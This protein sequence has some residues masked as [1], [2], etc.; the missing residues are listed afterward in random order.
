MH[1]GHRRERVEQRVARV[2]EE[3]VVAGDRARGIEAELGQE[4]GRRGREERV[5]DHRDRHRGE[6]RV[7]DEAEAAAVAEVED[8]QHQAAALEVEVRVAPAGD[9]GRPAGADRPVLDARLDQQAERA[10]GADQVA[11]VGEGE[12]HA[13]VDGAAGVA[14]GPVGGGEQEELED[15]VER[16][17]AAGGALR[18]RLA[19]TV[20][21]MR[22]IPAA[23]PAE[24]CADPY[25][26][27]GSW[28]QRGPS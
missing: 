15:E 9:L 4:A 13:A 8:R 21:P 23:R 17:R 3:R 19:L 11:R 25:W 7:A 28:W 16:A 27:T 5:A 2:R 26:I 12:P 6:D 1:R 18:S 22:A 24:D 20:P 10:L 14:P